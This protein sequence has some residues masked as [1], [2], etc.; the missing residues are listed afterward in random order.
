MNAG[1]GNLSL[2]TTTLLPDAMQPDTQWSALLQSVGQGV[3]AQ[4]EKFC[5][6]KLAYAAGDIAQFNA[7]RKYLSLPRYP[8]VS[9][10]DIAQSD[11]ADQN[12][13]SLG[14]VNETV[15]QINFPSGLIE[16][17]YITGPHFSRLQVTYTGGYWFETKEPTDEGYPTALPAGATPLPADLLDA[18][19]EQCLF[20]F[21]ERD[22][23]GQRAIQKPGK[24]SVGDYR[25]AEIGLTQRV[26]DV[27]TTYRRYSV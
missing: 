23:L 24:E 14:P 5:N 2:L 9:V 7:D 25:F 19:L 11:T 8:L 6:R 21:K 18:W 1:L 27:L 15:L 3:A 20:L 13:Q 26:Q 22:L 10:A 17:G 12:F 16:F 4:F